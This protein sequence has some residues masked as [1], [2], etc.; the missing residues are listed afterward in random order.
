MYPNVADNI[1]SIEEKYPLLYTYEYNG[2]P[3]WELIRYPL[4][5]KLN[6]CRATSYTDRR[7]KLVQLFLKKFKDYIYSFITA[8]P[9]FWI[10]KKRVLLFRCSRKSFF[11]DKFLDIYTAHIEE[12]YSK[13]EIGIYETHRDYTS[14]SAHVPNISFF[15]LISGN[16]SSLMMRL[17]RKPTQS[18]SAVKGIIAQEGLSINFEE[19]FWRQY[20]IFKVE[21]FFYSTLFSIR[22]PE[23]I[24]IVN[25]INKQAM[26]AEAKKRGIE[27]H[28]LQHGFTSPKLLL[29]HYPFA[30]KESLN[31]FPSVFHYIN[32][33]YMCGCDIP[34]KQEHVVQNISGYLQ[35]NECLKQ[36]IQKQPSTILF[37]SQHLIHNQFYSWV[38]DFCYYVKEQNLD[39]T[40]LYKPHPLEYGMFNKNELDELVDRYNLKLLPKD[41]HILK[42]MSM[43][44]NVVG[45][46]STA[47]LEAR[48]MG[49]KILLLNVPGVENFEYI[50]KQYEIP[51]VNNPEELVNILVN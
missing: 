32:K 23:H 7:V 31:F 19:L 45:V 26:I 29:Y 34:L 48:A 8:N 1:L 51:T 10:S 24:Y 41:S 5:I 28:E 11:N 18:V 4:F 35:N 33:D 37:V 27:I 3:I 50:A 20:I 38:K 13:E 14:G 42:S 9:L 22:C 16:V 44:G 36:S 40:I 49:C 39:Y 30:K 6:K 21:S 46:Y 15:T 47:L 12:L 17:F 43:S 25:Y 2:V